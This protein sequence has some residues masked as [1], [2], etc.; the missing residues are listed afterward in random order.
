MTK[1]KPTKEPEFR[2]PRGFPGEAPRV[3]RAGQP[4]EKQPTEETTDSQPTEE[5]Q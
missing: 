4:V 1:P 3:R 2:H 5:N